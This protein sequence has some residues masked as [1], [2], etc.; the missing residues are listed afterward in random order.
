[1]PSSEVTISATKHNF[2]ILIGPLCG[3]ISRGAAA[4]ATVELQAQDVVA[5]LSQQTN[6]VV[7]VFEI[8]L[9]LKVTNRSD[10]PINVPTLGRINDTT[11]FVTAVETQ[12]VDGSWSFLSQASFYGTETTKYANCSSLRPGASRAVE[13]L[14]YVLPLLKARARELGKEPKLR[15]SVVMFCR[16]ADGVLNVSATTEPF[17]LL[18]PTSDQ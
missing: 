2:L 10:K 5:K 15:V 13:G 16:A 6:S 12:R 7:T 17:R 1:M 14:V 4:D 3:A 8:Q 9:N 11:T 18:L